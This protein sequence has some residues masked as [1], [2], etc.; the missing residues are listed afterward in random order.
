MAAVD[1][2]HRA[3]VVI[4]GAGPAGLVTAV[5]LARNGAGSLL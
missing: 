3:P 2:L 5:T 1:R 4:V